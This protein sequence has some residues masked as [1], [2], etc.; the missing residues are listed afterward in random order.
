MSKEARFVKKYYEKKVKD[1]FTKHQLPFNEYLI[2]DLMQIIKTE[3]KLREKYRSEMINAL[4]AKSNDF[5]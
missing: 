2:A 4:I 1:A 3:F 5:Y